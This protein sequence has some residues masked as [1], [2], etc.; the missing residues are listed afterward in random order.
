LGLEKPF[1]NNQFRSR[2]YA[3]LALFDMWDENLQSPVAYVAGPFVSKP[4]RRNG[5]ASNP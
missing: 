2:I 5:G 4:S 3:S 1:V